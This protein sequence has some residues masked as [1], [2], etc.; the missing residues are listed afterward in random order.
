MSILCT[1]LRVLVASK[2]ST[3]SETR[4]TLSI[5][6]SRQFGV[7]SGVARSAAGFDSIF[8]LSKLR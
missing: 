8:F 7:A 4:L 1:S 5:Y 6:S 2:K 3:V